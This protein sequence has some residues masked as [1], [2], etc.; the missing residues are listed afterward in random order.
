ASRTN[1][2]RLCRM[3]ARCQPSPLALPHAPHDMREELSA[4][5]DAEAAIESRHVLMGRGV[6]QVEARGDLLLAIP[7]QQTAERLAEPRGEYLRARLS[8]ADQRS[9]D[10]GADLLVKEVQHLTL[11]R[12][13]VPL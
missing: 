3:L 7:L 1:A 9:A 11:A 13:E 8:H 2:S 10:Q 6:A 4:A 12:R 5:L